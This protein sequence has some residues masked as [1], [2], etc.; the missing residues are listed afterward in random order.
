[1]NKA[2][3]QFAI[4][5]IA[6]VAGVAQCACYCLLAFVRIV[7]L[8][9]VTGWIMMQFVS[10][11][12]IMPLVSSVAMVIVAFF[13]NRKAVLVTGVISGLVTLLFLLL[14]RTILLN[15]DPTM[16]LRVIPGVQTFIN[17]YGQMLP[18]SIGT[19]GMLM[20]LCAVV[21][22]ASAFF[23]S[24]TGNNP[25]GPDWPSEEGPTDWPSSN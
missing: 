17:Q 15:A 3:V 6:L 21:Y 8:I 25:A 5:P 1:M 22:I 2:Q 18:V 9:P 12:M 4:N 24:G 11:I 14:G 23:M 19:G 20:L 16:L 10:P 7:G 13:A